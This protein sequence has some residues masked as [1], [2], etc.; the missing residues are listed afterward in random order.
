LFTLG[1]GLL[2]G[3]FVL[4]LGELAL[5]GVRGRLALAARGLE[6]FLGHLVLLHDAVLLEVGR[7]QVQREPLLAGLA[8][9]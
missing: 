5:V 3:A 7:R 2:E 6:Q 8:S 9:N 1:L 4:L